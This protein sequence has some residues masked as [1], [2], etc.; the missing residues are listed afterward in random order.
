MQARHL[1]KIR[2]RR[3]AGCIGVDVAEQVG[4]QLYRFLFEAGA[5]VLDQCSLIDLRAPVGQCP[6]HRHRQLPQGD[7]PGQQIA[8]GCCGVVVK[9][10][11]AGQQSHQSGDHRRG[12]EDA[13][14][15]AAFKRQFGR[16]LPPAVPFGSEQIVVVDE[17]LV[18]GDLIE[19]VFAG[20][21]HDR[22]DLKSGGVGGHD[23][24]AESGVPMRGVQWPGAGQYYHLMG[25]VRATGPYLLS[26]EDPAAVGANRFHRGGRQIRPGL[27]LAHA[28]R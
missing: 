18:E 11:L 3:P 25:Q 17:H 7:Q 19:M 23:E 15:A 13:F 27:W 4:G 6:R 28:D 1:H 20:E 5:Q 16:H 9:V 26:G 10:V 14:G 2:H 21:Q 24:L 12:A 22:A 8:H